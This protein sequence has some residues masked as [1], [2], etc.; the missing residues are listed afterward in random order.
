MIKPTLQYKHQTELDRLIER[1]AILSQRTTYLKSLQ[2]NYTDPMMASIQ[3]EFEQER[4][5]LQTPLKQHQF[6]AALQKDYIWPCLHYLND[7][8]QLAET[9]E[10][11]TLGVFK[12][13]QTI[14]QHTMNL[15]S[16]VE[17]Q[18]QHQDHPAQY[19]DQLSQQL[20]TIDLHQSFKRSP[21]FS[22]LHDERQHYARQHWKMV[23]KGSF[24]PHEDLRLQAMTLEEHA[25]RIQHVLEN[26]KLT[27]ALIFGNMSRIGK[28]IEKVHLF[29]DD[30]LEFIVGKIR[31]DNNYRILW[32]QAIDVESAEQELQ[33]TTPPS[34]MNQNRH[35][36]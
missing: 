32:Q 11:F 29:D 10:G 8:K 23:W 36:L 4:Q 34:L 26:A 19:F 33:K 18:E 27:P 21:S 15:T 13:L 20:A 28:A 7:L 12:S 5:Q 16:L 17:H 14:A 9:P 24:D 31:F 30:V 25:Y 6:L 1:N 2:Q 35:R 3:D 22:I